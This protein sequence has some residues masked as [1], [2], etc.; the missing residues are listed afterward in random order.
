MGL[1]LACLL[2]Q[3]EL[4]V[5][6]IDHQVPDLADLKSPYDI[7]VNAIHLAS[8][9]IFNTLGVWQHI[10]ARRVSPYHRMRV[11]DAASPAQ[12]EFDSSEISQPYL[13][14][15]LEQSVMRQALWQQLK[16]H[17]NVH[18]YF[19]TAPCVLHEKID[20]VD[21]KLTNNKTISASLLVGADGKKS[22]VARH[23]F[24]DD[25][26][27]QTHTDHA[28]LI[29]TLRTEHPHQQTALQRFLA[30]GPVA[31]L[32]L[33]DPY[34]VSLVWSTTTL[35]AEMLKALPEAEFSVK[36]EQAME[37]ALGKLTVCDTR[38]IFPLH[39]HQAPHYVK[40]RVALVGD[41]AHTILPLAG[42]GLNLGLLDAACLSQIISE[43]RKTGRDIGAM[44]SLRRYERWRKGENTAMLLAMEGFNRLFANT[45]EASRFVRHIGFSLTKKLP[46]AKKYFMQR[47]TGLRGELPDSA[48]P[49]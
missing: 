25:F 32:P 45:F 19:E 4:S 31:L 2:A 40:T 46:W 35:E 44:L 20:T 3:K 48:K 47:A 5:A 36:L 10:E 17:K 33:A 30:T 13:G 16:T 26:S 9:A 18:I 21:V 7:R 29:A 41:A 38:L 27:A 12:I 49:L 6:L 42:Q 24:P 34:L 23:A 37:Y 8:A 28:A 15:I 14:Y 11:W 39:S 22:W 43:T 1:T